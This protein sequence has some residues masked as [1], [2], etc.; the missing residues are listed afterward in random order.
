MLKVFVLALLLAGCGTKVVD[1]P[2]PD[3]YDV[4][5]PTGDG[6]VDWGL[7]EKRYGKQDVR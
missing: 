4:P 5:V 7:T 1:M 2:I 6:E 3:M